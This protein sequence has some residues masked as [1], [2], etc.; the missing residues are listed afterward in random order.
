MDDGVE[1]QHCVV[2]TT[3]VEAQHNIATRG[4][5]QCEVDHGRHREYSNMDVGGG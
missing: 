3:G 1:P 5:V 4:G 2:V